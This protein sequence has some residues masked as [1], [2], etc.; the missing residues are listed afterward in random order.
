MGQRLIISEEEKRT[1]QGMY[2]LVN[3]Q[4][5]STDKSNEGS[6][7]PAWI[8]LSKKLKGIGNP[9]V[10][11][12]KDDDGIPIETLNWGTAKSSNG[13]FAFAIVSP[14]FGQN[15]GP[16][17][18]LFDSDDKDRNVKITDWWLNRGYKPKYDHR[19]LGMTPTF[20]NFDLQDADKLVSD[21]KSF[22]EEYPPE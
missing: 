14:E 7:N 1:I 12:W 20:F 13:N 5:S 19:D 9:K 21:V 6:N 2:G 18:H 11:R 10:I 3:E 4:E 22:F 15:M 8:N 16:E 17:I